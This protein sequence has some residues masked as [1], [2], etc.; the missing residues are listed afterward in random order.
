M[1][2]SI[3]SLFCWKYVMLKGDCLVGGVAKVGTC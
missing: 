2:G 3:V 1:I